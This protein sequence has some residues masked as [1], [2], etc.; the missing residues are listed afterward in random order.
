MGSRIPEPIGDALRIAAARAS[1]F[2]E[3]IAGAKMEAVWL[4]SALASIAL[5]FSLYWG[6]T[7]LA[8]FL[9]L[10]GIWTLFR[11]GWGSGIIWLAIAIPVGFHYAL[12]NKFNNSIAE[13][14]TVSPL[15]AEAGRRTDAA[16]EEGARMDK[17]K[18]DIEASLAEAETRRGERAPRGGIEEEKKPTANKQQDALAAPV[19]M[20]ID[21][22]EEVQNL[23]A[24]AEKPGEPIK[25]VEAIE[26]E[27]AEATQESNPFANSPE[28]ER[29]RTDGG[30]GS[31]VKPEAPPFREMKARRSGRWRPHGWVW[32]YRIHTPGT[33]RA[34]PVLSFARL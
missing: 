16:A 8:L 2:C 32:T 26:T 13:R 23:K 9:G 14:R 28:I 30:H 24:E 15:V 10:T 34:G 19:D 17:W 21:I 6:L 11:A 22:V 4:W 1:G 5:I 20:D 18:K 7:A 29:P 27:Q 25:Q 12:Q 3:R 31:L 33:A